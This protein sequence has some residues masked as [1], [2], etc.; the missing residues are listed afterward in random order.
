MIIKSEL[1]TAIAQ[2]HSHM[3][4]KDVELSIN[5]LIDYLCDALA[6]G[7]RIEVRG[8]GSFTLH[9]RPPRQAHNPKTGK[10]LVTESK[11]TPHFKPGKELKDRVNKHLNDQ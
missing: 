3:L 5:R 4:E 9:H 6:Q 2:H 10:K 11:Y 8:F 7:E 1:V